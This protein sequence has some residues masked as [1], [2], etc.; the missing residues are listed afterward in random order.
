M[1]RR[2]LATEAIGNWRPVFA[3]QGP[4][5]NYCKP[6]DVAHQS[7]FGVVGEQSRAI[8]LSVEQV[9]AKQMPTIEQN[10]PEKH[11]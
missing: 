9:A 10:P 4:E 11:T 8:R 3:D 5:P 6:S 1:S 7:R 2:T